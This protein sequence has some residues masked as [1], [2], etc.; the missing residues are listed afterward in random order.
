MESISATISLQVSHTRATVYPLDVQ[1]QRLEAISTKS[2]DQH[3]SFEINRKGQPF[4]AN[5]EVTIER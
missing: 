4:A 1:G 3:L 2:N 5:Y